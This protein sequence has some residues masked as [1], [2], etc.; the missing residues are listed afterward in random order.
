MSIFVPTWEVWNGQTRLGSVQAFNI[1]D[2]IRYMEQ[3]IG[4][5]F[6]EAVAIPLDME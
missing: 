6:P 4:L 2:A 1:A 5:F 3:R